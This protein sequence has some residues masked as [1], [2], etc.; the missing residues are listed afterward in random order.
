MAEHEEPNMEIETLSDDD[1]ESVSGGTDTASGGVCTAAG[2]ICTAAGGICK[3][4]E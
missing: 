3:L 2:G 1:L 4:G